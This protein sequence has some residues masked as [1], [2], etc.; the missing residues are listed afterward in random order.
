MEVLQ[1]VYHHG[2]LLGPSPVSSWRED[3]HHFA[4]LGA[5]HCFTG[6]WNGGKSASGL[7]DQLN[8]GSIPGS[9]T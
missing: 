3:W 4:S 6:L 7:R 5:H 9:P 2:A 1:A 8:L